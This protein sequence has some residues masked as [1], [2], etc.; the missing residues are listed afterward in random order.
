M[1]KTLRNLIPHHG[2]T[3]REFA[4]ALR[5]SYS[6]AVRKVLE[7]DLT[8]LADQEV[9]EIE[10]ALGSKPGTFVAF[11]RAVKEAHHAYLQAN[12]PRAPRGGP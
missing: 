8:Q 11:I 9:V 2:L 12:P 5:L 6:Q 4:E 10:R 3:T 7:W 1:N